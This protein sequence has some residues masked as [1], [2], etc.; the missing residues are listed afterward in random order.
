VELP[1]GYGL[2][3]ITADVFDR[4]GGGAVRPFGDVFRFLSGGIE[5]LARRVSAGPAVTQFGSAI[6]DRSLSSRWAFNQALRQLGAERGG[7]F[8]EF[9]ALGLGSPPQKSG[10]GDTSSN[11]HAGEVAH[12]R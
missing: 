7:S 11:E 9:D 5:A 4:L 6:P 8:D 3:A 1:Q 12:G 10:P 2:L